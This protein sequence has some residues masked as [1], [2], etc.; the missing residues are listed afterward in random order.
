MHKVICPRCGSTKNIDYVQILRRRLRYHVA[1]IAHSDGVTTLHISNLV[2]DEPVD[3]MSNEDRLE[4]SC[5]NRW[6][7][8]ADEVENDVLE[9]D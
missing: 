4:C 2:S 7:V 6:T 8:D 3:S 9:E 5:G 1:A